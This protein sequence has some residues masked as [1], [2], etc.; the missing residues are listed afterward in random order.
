M[1]PNAMWQK[2][3]IWTWAILALAGCASTVP[4]KYAR[5]AE[6]PVSTEVNHENY[7]FSVIPP[8][9]LL[10]G[11]T[12]NVYLERAEPRNTVLYSGMPIHSYTFSVTLMGQ[13]LDAAMFAHIGTTHQKGLRFAPSPYNSLCLVGDRAITGKHGNTPVRTYKAICHNPANDE[14]Y[15]LALTERSVLADED[16]SALFGAMRTF[17]G[18]FRFK[19]SQ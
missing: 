10:A 1:K 6:L 19:P 5:V 8:H 12:W 4:E 3:R 2:M 15:E 13:N 17:L 7:S 14:V 9:S 18:S 16:S 11:G